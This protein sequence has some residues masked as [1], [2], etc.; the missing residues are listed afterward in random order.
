MPLNDPSVDQTDAR[1]VGVRVLAN[2]TPLPGVISVEL[3][4]SN[5][6]QCDRFTFDAALKAGP[7]NWWDVEPPFVIDIQLNLD[8]GGWQ[9][10][11]QGEVDTQR[12]A[13]H[14]GRITCPGRD[15]S[16]RLIET[17]TQITY[18]NMTSSQIAQTLAAE[19][20][21]STV[22][23]DGNLTVTATTTLAGRY[24]D[25]DHTRTSLGQFAKATTEWDLLTYLAQQEGF[26]VYV[27]GQVLYFQPTTSPNADPYVFQWTP[28]DVPRANLLTLNLERS[29]TLAKDIEI[30]VRS[31][32]SRSKNSFT[33]TV[34]GSGTR[35]ASATG[36]T[37]SNKAISTQR[38]VFV[39]PNLTQAQALQFGQQMLAELT[40]HERIVEV[41]M[42]GELTLTPRNMVRLQ[43]TGSSFDQVY[44]VDRISRTLAFEGGFLQTVRLKNSSP[45]TLAAAGAAGQVIV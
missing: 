16:G 10:I 27:R 8:G 42:P 25:I 43:G 1:S 29:L 31:W 3:T 45:R 41:T 13:F 33:T 7:A 23:A 37:P 32:S 26:D 40:K 19:H 4:S 28:A 2:G 5:G 6:Y 18:Q 38:Y 9:S 17:K 34:T 44:Y 14:S 15:F 35:L 24:Y 21:L 30:Q 12:I 20:G 22:D 39:K 36:V 11:L